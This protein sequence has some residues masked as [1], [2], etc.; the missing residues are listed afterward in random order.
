MSPTLWSAVVAVLAATTLSVPVIAFAGGSNPHPAFAV[1]GNRDGLH[2]AL[3]ALYLGLG[4]DT[5]GM[6]GTSDP[7]KPEDPADEDTGRNGL[8]LTFEDGSP[9][10]RYA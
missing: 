2:A 7:E 1:R 10:L 6:S 3:Y 8:E 5:P 9:L 4:R